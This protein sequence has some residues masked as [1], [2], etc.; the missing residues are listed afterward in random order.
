MVPQFLKQAKFTNMKLIDG[1]G[2][3]KSSVIT[4]DNQIF[5]VV[6]N[7]KC[8][9]MMY[10]LLSFQNGNK[11]LTPIF[12]PIP[13][14]R[15]EDLRIIPLNSFQL[16]F[17]ITKSSKLIIGK[18]FLSLSKSL[19]CDLTGISLGSNAVQ[20]LAI[21]QLE[22]TTESKSSSIYQIL[23]RSKSMD[24]RTF[25][26]LF[27][28]SFI[29]NN[30]GWIIPFGSEEDTM[31]IKPSQISTLLGLN[32]YIL[33]Q[34]E[35]EIIYFQFSSISRTLLSSALC[36]NSQLPEEPSSNVSFD[37][38]LSYF[39][40]YCSLVRSTPEEFDVDKFSS[41]FD[42]GLKRKFPSAKA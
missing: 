12:Y 36:I 31:K 18:L 39:L 29:D 33:G 24:G 22:Q 17:A 19:E 8:E 4:I 21:N 35:N 10:S 9:M 34:K 32:A 23:I 1:E 20:F 40:S 37:K 25:D 38:L 7:K 3:R 15:I 26:S 27:G 5:I 28:F 42:I 41:L 30:Y 2:S 11:E 16:L 14:E 13:G 6:L